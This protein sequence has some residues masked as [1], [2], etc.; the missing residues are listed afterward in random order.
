M[1]NRA[2]GRGHGGGGGGGD[3]VQAA[4]QLLLSL[5][6]EGL[7]RGGGGYA[8]GGRPGGG[9]G[10]GGGGAQSRGGEWGCCCGFATNRAYRDHCFSCGRPRALGES[11]RA[12]GGGGGHRQQGTPGEKG[13]AREFKGKGSVPLGEARRWVDGP[14][15]A[16]GAKPVL[17][18]AATTGPFASTSSAKGGPWL[19]K[20]STPGR[21]NGG[22]QGK[23]PAPADGVERA[24][25]AAKEA[26]ERVDGAKGAWTKP[27]EHVDEDGYKLV[28]PRRTWAQVAG[29]GLQAAPQAA[30]AATLGRAAR[31]RWSDEASD[32]D[33]DEEDDCDDGDDT[34]G[35]HGGG[36]EEADEVDPRQLRSRYEAIAKAVRDMEKRGGG[37]GSDPA[38]CAL[39]SARDEAEAAWRAA[40]V[41]APL[42]T[43]MGRAEAKLERAAAALGRARLALESFDEWADHQR[44]QLARQVDEAEQWHRWR[45]QQLHDLHEEAGEKAQGRRESSARATGGKADISGRILGDLLPQ[46]H[47]IREHLQ[48]NPEVV[49][50]LSI[51]A[52]GLES[53]GQDLHGRGGAAVEQFDI[54]SDT[55]RETCDGEQKPAGTGQ[56][57]ASGARHGGKGP[58]AVA[59]EPE[60]PGRWTR[61]RHGA[62]HT[63]GAATTP[64]VG[65]A[66]GSTSCDAADASQRGNNG[67]GKRAAEDTPAEGNTAGAA[68]TLPQP[69]VDAMAEPSATED[70]TGEA[71]RAGKHR[72]QQTEAEQREADDRRRAEELQEQQRRAIEA[73]QASH[74]AG[75]GGFGSNTALDL[76]AQ[77]FVGEVQKA[78]EQARRKGIEPVSDGRQLLELTPAELREWVT[79]NLGDEANWT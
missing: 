75:T 33:M 44:Q 22:G 68:G 72:R 79:A 11:Q 2:R 74:A 36:K 47:E 37:G 53:A 23:G 18:N 5:F 58:G 38:L 59:W 54:G 61:A 49:E 56:S 17:G 52:A 50:R 60:G 16:K 28:Q 4:R 25:H 15:G 73:Q 20:G 8:G 7:P 24:G 63:G 43:R 10:R 39:K 29:G 66:S 31:P 65:S 42:P 6:G 14:L 48:G 1:R 71:A 45:E 13:G 30:P 3:N 19:P 9:A 32:A 62:Q 12:V 51:L 26:G 35:D 41:P 27:T 40:K 34:E 77:R 69:P 21:P 57:G 70:A 46:V 55:M 76:A 64:A 67:R 78:T